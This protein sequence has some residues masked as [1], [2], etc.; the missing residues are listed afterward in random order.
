MID[1]SVIT[2][3]D[4][5]FLNSFLR[6]I[7]GFTIRKTNSFQQGL[8]DTLT[9][10]INATEDDI[11]SFLTSNNHANRSRI[12]SMA[13]NYDASHIR[14]IKALQ[15][16]LKDRRACNALPDLVTLEAI[17]SNSLRTLVRNR[18]Q[19]QET[20]KR[21]KSSDKGEVEIPTLSSTNFEDVEQKIKSAASRRVGAAGIPLDYILRTD[22]IGNYDAIWSNRL[23]KLK[24]CINLYGDDYTLDNHTLYDMLVGCIKTGSTGHATLTSYKVSKNGRQ[25]LLDL[26]SMFVTTSTRDNKAS[27]ANV[28]IAGAFYDGN[29]RN[30]RLEDYFNRMNAAFVHLE[31]AGTQY[32]LNEHQKIQ[33]FEA[34]LHGNNIITQ[35]IEAKTTWDKLPFSQQTFQEYF[36]LYS[37]RISKFNTLS[38]SSAHKQNRQITNINSFGRGRGRGR[39][40]GRGR[41]RSNGRGRGGRINKINNFSNN[42]NNSGGTIAP[43]YGST[44]QAK[45]FSREEWHNMSREDKQAI[46][47]LKNNEGWINNYTPPPGYSLNPQGLPIQNSVINATS[48]SNIPP[49][50]P[51]PSDIQ[52]PHPDTVSQISVNSGQAGGAFGRTPARS[53][54]A[55]SNVE[56]QQQ[57]ATISPVSIAGRPYTGA[58]Y[59]AH[60][61]RLN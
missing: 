8:G 58:I 61:R 56:R 41:G 7:L 3:D 31:E 50:P 36:N 25:V 54:A 2:M 16:E 6:D 5:T 17:D 52:I 43:R 32:S 45:L 47:T 29:K 22:S 51:H 27:T 35:H 48:T 39:V 14:S 26:Q 19:A 23:D 20:E 9:D 60:G 46:N 53:V 11:D 42:T 10:L 30:F 57:P 37:A 4:P 33:K 13:C 44:L 28:T 34:G 1:L 18:T 55:I 49:L 38:S 15:F 21:L 24:H 12:N 59:D 40:N